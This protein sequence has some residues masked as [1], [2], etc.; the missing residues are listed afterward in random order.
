M[1][2]EKNLQIRQLEKDKNAALTVLVNQVEAYRAMALAL[3]E[4]YMN[5][6]ELEHDWE[7]YYADIGKAAKLIHEADQGD[8]WIKRFSHNIVDIGWAQEIIHDTKTA[9][10]MGFKGLYIPEELT[11]L[12]LEKSWEEFCEEHDIS[13]E[14]EYD[15][16]EEEGIDLDEEWDNV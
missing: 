3:S 13:S 14:D 4:P 15:Y 7:K 9:D 5:L 6:E 12:K 10:E 1:L 2:T 11:A 8:A 16:F